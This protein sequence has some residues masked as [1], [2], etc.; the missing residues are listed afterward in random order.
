LLSPTDPGAA[1]AAAPLW[2]TGGNVV[3]VRAGTIRRGAN[4]AVA[5]GRITQVTT[6]VPPAG[7]RQIALGGR[8][9][10]PGLISVHTHLSVVY[11]F[12]ATDESESAGVTALRALS[13]AQD[14]LQAGVTTIRCVHEQ[15]RADLLIRAAAEEGWV[16]APRIL[17][18]GR[19]L[20]TT[21]GHGHGSA[22]VYADGYDGFLHAA[23]AELAAGA[24]HLKIF[25]TGGIARQGE[26]FDGAEMTD[27]EMRA[28]VRAASERGSYVVA[29]A[30]SA[31]A[32]RQALQAGVRSFE[33]AY[34]LD[35]DTAAEMARRRVFLTP[36]LCVTRCPEWMADHRFTPWQVERAMEVGP[37]HL[38]SIRTAVRAGLRPAGG[39]EAGITFVAGTDYPPGE[40]IEDTVV[41]VREMEFLTDAG[42]SPEQALRAGTADA[43][44]LV[45]LED[46]LG[47]VDEGYA[48]DL[49]VADAD[50]LSDIRALRRIGLVM[51]GGRVVRN[52]LPEPGP[53]DVAPAAGAAAV[54]AGA[55]R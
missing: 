37:A 28:V 11:P 20:S 35:D 26:S 38:E 27:E 13:R 47:A 2:L 25:I 43:A 12:S 17:G 40:P 50:P 1:A 44:R 55:G 36:T 31:G 6:D 16:A 7:A 54:G 51:Q 46:Q 4:V 15:N 41:A 18:A 24:D 45:K 22:C 30:G 8:F 9:V 42:L 49:I 52:E 10:L 5:G 3:D 14:A 33:H 32:M 19:A 23:R 21:G 39:D 53:G 34:Q 48:A 29:H